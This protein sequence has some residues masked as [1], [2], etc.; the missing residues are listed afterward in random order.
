MG[1][2]EGKGKWLIVKGGMGSVSN[3]LAKLAEARGVEMRTNSEVAEIIVSGS[4][5]NGIR[6]SDGTVIEAP[7]VISNTTHHVTFK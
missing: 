4:K 3:Y 5:V 6:L 1:E 2:L 7:I